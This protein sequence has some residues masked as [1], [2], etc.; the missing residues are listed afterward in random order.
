[1]TKRHDTRAKLVTKT[2][3]RQLTVKSSYYTYQANQLRHQ[4]ADVTEI[5]LK[6]IWLAQAGFQAGENVTVRVMHGCLVI[7]RKEITPIINHRPDPG[8]R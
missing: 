7:T 1:M 6:G 8:L 3:Q 4:R 5:L 2:N